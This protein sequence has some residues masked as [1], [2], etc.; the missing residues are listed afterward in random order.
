MPNPY[1]EI[2]KARGAK[3][4]AAAGFVA[5]LPLAMVTMGIVAMLSQTHGEYWL[6]GAVSA[7]FA[8]ANAFVSP[9]VSRLVDR[10]G[11]SRVLTLATALS[12]A[13]FAG[14]IV[15]TH[16]RWP[17]WTLFV[18]A[19]AASVMPSMPAM[20]R[21]RWSAL[22]RDTPQLQTAFA[23]ESVADEVV[24]MLGSIASVGLSVALFPEAG[25]MASTTFLAVG[26][27][28]FVMQ[29]ST[30]PA[31][32]AVVSGGGSA[33][34][35]G[36]VKL[37]T[38]VLAAIGTIFGTAEVT[39]I[40][41]T[42]EFGRQ[43]AASFVLAGY[44]TGSLIVGLVYGALKLTSSLARQF[45]TAIAFAALMTLP[46]LFVG[47]IPALALALFLGGASIS[48]TFITAFGLIERLVPAS[49]LTEGIT[50]AMTGIGIGMAAGSFTSGWV[51]DQFGAG[52]GFWVS[53]AA[54]GIA[55][56]T[57]LLGYA[58][59]TTPARSADLLAAIT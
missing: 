11:Q 15:A 24:Y 49:K 54:G 58:R 22:Y 27:M 28:F 5:R 33:F 19:L 46:L 40:A 36:A 13:A 35:F 2:F 21:A 23:F 44:A 12:V 32:E 17:S 47:N 8:L 1:R 30:E 41:L 14:L 53:V 18:F 7:T 51:I 56:A 59:L 6:A 45:L 4:F 20:V 38:F 48:P 3:G 9:L 55:L 52:N 57:A 37:L 10:H 50:W 39:V 31:I 16:Y 42:Q 26:T 25:P 43:G 34:R 29:K